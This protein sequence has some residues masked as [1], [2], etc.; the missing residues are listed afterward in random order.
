MTDKVKSFKSGS[1]NVDLKKGQQAV[2]LK[3]AFL[4]YGIDLTSGEI[5]K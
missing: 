2:N 1:R 3:E 4:A 5:E